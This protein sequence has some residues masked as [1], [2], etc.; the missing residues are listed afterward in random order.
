GHRRSAAG[1]LRGAQPWDGMPVRVAA[2]CF[3]ES[4]GNGSWEKAPC[5]RVGRGA[6]RAHWPR[7]DFARRPALGSGYT[8]ETTSTADF[9]VHALRFMREGSSIRRRA[10]I[11]PR[12]ELASRRRGPP[13]R[14]LATEA[15]PPCRPVEP[16]RTRS[17]PWP[18]HPGARETGPG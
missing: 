1:G 7:A 9:S 8:A 16:F 3:R 11:S 15:C 14:R 10:S 4:L 2:W 12:V 5:G 6:R 17:E 13:P 18:S